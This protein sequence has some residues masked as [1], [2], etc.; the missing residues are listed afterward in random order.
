M[1]STLVLSIAALFAASVHASPLVDA[2]QQCLKL[3]AS[4]NRLP[5]IGGLRCCT[6]LVCDWDGQFC[7]SAISTVEK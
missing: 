5:P 7:K 4:C 1:K 3:G 6:F 2:R